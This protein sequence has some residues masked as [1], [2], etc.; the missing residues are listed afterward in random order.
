MRSIVRCAV[1]L[2]FVGLNYMTPSAAVDLCR[3]C[4]ECIYADEMDS[5]DEGVPCCGYAVEGV[6]YC[7][8]HEYPTPHCFLAD[9]GGAC[10]LQ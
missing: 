3:I 1:T 4:T 5:S 9:D 8:I 10:D 2:A 6:P 7:N